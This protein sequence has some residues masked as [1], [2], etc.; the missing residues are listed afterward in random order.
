MTL[1]CAKST[2]PIAGALAALW[3]VSGALAA[4]ADSVSTTAADGFGRMVFS[5]AAPAHVQ[6]VIAG[7]VLT[8][9]FDRNVAVDPASIQQ[10]LPAYIARAHADPDG[11]TFRF[12]LTES[13]SLHTSSS[14]SRTAIDLVPAGYA[15]TPPDLPPPP[16]V[17]PTAV[18]I[19]KLPA[20]SVRAGAYSNFTRLVFDWPRPVPYAVFPGA[21]K[22]TI[23]F[24]AMAKPD[25]S[26]FEHVSPP[27]VKQAG[28]RI[29]NKGTIVEFDTD[30][31][32]GYHDFRDGSKVVLD[33]LAPKTD[34]QAYRP[35]SPGGV[36]PRPTTLTPATDFVAGAQAQAVADVAAQLKGPIADTRKSAGKPDAQTQ[37]PQT[38]PPSQVAATGGAPK[39]T[40]TTSPLPASQLPGQAQA[41]QPQPTPTV[42]QAPAV[43]GA[44]AATSRNNAVLTFAKA[45]TRPVAVF[46]RGLTAWVV[47]DGAVPLDPVKLKAELVQFSDSVAAST[48]DGA[49]IL[50]VG[51][52]QPE[53]VQAFSQGADLKVMIAPR[54][55]IAPTAIGF[56]HDSDEPSRAALTTLLPGAVRVLAL[57]DPVAGDTLTVIPALPGRAQ[58]SSRRFVDFAS[59]QTAA[60]LVLTPFR[61]DLQ[62][63]ANDSHVRI[64]RPG[65]LKLS[66][67]P[68]PPATSPAALASGDLSPCYLDLAAWSRVESGSFAVIQQKLRANVARLTPNGANAA[69]LTLARFYLAKG[70]A[71]ET[72]GMLDLMQAN[73]P[74]LQND[75]Q[76]QTMRAA[77]DYMMGRYA[78]AHNDIAGTAFDSDR[79]A[80]FWRGL[81]EAA[82]ENWDDARTALADAEP[83]F[84]RYPAVWQAQARIAEAK[85]YLAEKNME[86]ADSALSKL[87]R[88]LPA[89]LMYEAELARARL[90]AQEGRLRDAM[91][92]FRA[93]ENG[94]DGHAA[95]EAIY[96]RVDAALAAGAMTPAEAT[97]DLEALRYRWRGDLLE[98]DTLRRLGALYFAQKKWRNGFEVLR[99]ASQNFPNNDLA[100]QA[101]DDM[102]REF[103]ELFLKGKA[104][105]IPPIQA[106]GL[107]YDFI[108]LT[109]IGPD[110]DEMIRRMTNRLMAVDLLSPAAKLLDYQ[111]N[112]RLDGAARAQVA[113]RLAMIELLD[114][115]PKEALATLKT[116]EMTGLPDDVNHQRLLLQ[117]RALAALKQWDQALD[118]I[119]VDEAPDSRQL[120]ADIYW[121]SGNWEVAAQ[122]AEE[123]LD[124]RWHDAAPLSAHDRQLVMRAGIAYSL[125]GD[126]SSLNRLNDHFAAKMNGTPDASAFAVMMQDIDQHGVAF[127]E[128]AG[129]VASVDTFQQ[130]MKDFRAHYDAAPQTN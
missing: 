43:Q 91:P 79:H 77:A 52:K 54:I 124:D 130:F 92:L 99:T 32:A 62:V 71:A 59:L 60:G 125:A 96:Y 72:L 27:W 4:S 106:L 70:F 8:V 28:W 110:G 9:S 34:A 61:D 64:T 119:A 116:T 37:A 38:S 17:M 47:I 33:I 101:Q 78:D 115:K 122:K 117:A 40:A 25:F 111:V 29:E 94:S 56:A 74:G 30:A 18:E 66:L 80:A 14:G 100:R 123:L 107:F 73:D 113:G 20:L 89:P 35:P 39:P 81:I 120:R 10:G 45:G 6:P 46:V 105:S 58:T 36:R 65:G 102:R 97:D 19:S 84:H 98:L 87:P 11:K 63:V 16:P 50:R 69:R 86:L 68:A 22:L 83:V 129:K 5:L 108:D 49:T 24:E 51:L 31:A 75:L 121:E 82:L 57:P 26:A 103:A 7:G 2:W 127:R 88:D 13:F 15:G 126:Q 67:P 118:L 3:F 23:R 48:S 109:P 76:L 53:Q 104:D 95:A 41:Q 44:S 42:Q 90:Y 12:A 128:L 114:D 93:V 55:T 85:S 112:K 1:M 21:G